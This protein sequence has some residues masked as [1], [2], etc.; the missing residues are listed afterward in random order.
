MGNVHLGG[1]VDD[2]EIEPLGL[3]AVILASQQVVGLFQA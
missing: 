3:S 1:F 2:D